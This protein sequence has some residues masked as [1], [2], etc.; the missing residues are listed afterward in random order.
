MNHKFLFLVVLIFGGLF[1][2]TSYCQFPDPTPTPAYTMTLANDEAISATEFQCDIFIAR[3]GTTPFE[4]ALCQIGLTY[5]NAAKGTGTMT[6]SFV[7]GSTDPAIVASGQT[8]TFTLATN[9]AGY[10]K[11]PGH[12]ASGGIGTGAQ[13]TETPMKVGRL[14]L[15]N[16]V[17]FTSDP[18][19]LSWSFSGSYITKVFAYDPLDSKSYEITTQGTHSNT[20]DGPLP[21]EL[22]SF[23]SAVSGRQVNLNWETKTEINSNRYEIER[24][25]VS[26]KDAA[27]TWASVGTVKA[28]GSSSSIQKY[29]YTDKNLQTGKYQYRLKM[30]DFDGSYKYSSAIETE[31]AIPKDFELSQ[32]YPNPF[33]PS[34]RINYNLPFD[35]KVTLEVYNI[36]GERMGQIVNQEQSA[37]YYTV[38]FSSST[39]NRNI[40][41][42]VYIYKINAIDKSTGNVFS[43]IKKMM[44]LK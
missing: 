35:S 15:V 16:T 31:I 36:K 33:N 42:G 44:L 24:S 2:S 12:L 30:I 18:F 1:V 17:E 32:N 9:I 11:M 26:T 4:L 5:N 3:T 21:V 34:T 37:G 39:L 20:L 43:S 22:T 23:V 29:S 38:N 13:I 28:A 6:A 40:A 27:I 19:N 25:I 14:K 10:I 7:A 41:S 8:P